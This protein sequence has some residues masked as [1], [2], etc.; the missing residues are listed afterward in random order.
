M[1]PIVSDQCREARKNLLLY[2]NPMRSLPVNVMGCFDHALNCIHCYKWAKKNGL[3]D[4]LKK[5]AD[6]KMMNLKCPVCGNP[7]KVNLGFKIA[8][9][10]QCDYELCWDDP[11]KMAM[12]IVR[13]GE[14]LARKRGIEIGRMSILH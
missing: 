5:Y 2:N 10:F 8:K 7:M 6:N 9:C 13:L 3:Q 11:F 14:V 12:S 4:K 1:M